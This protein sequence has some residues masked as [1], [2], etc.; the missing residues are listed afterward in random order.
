LIL[1]DDVV[2]NN[3]RVA[4]HYKAIIKALG[5]EISPQKSHQSKSI[6][7]FAKRWIDV[8]QGEFTG[9]PT[10]GIIENFRNAFVVFT[11]LFDYFQLKG[12]QY[13]SEMTFVY[14]V[15]NLITSVN[16]R[17]LSSS[18][19]KRKTLKPGQ[20]KRSF[21]YLSNERLVS[22][23]KPY[24]LFMRYRMG[25]AT[26]DELRLFLCSLTAA[27]PEYQI[28]ATLAGINLEY[29][30]LI[31]HAIIGLAHNLGLKLRMYT[32]T[33]FRDKDSDVSYSTNKTHPLFYCIENRFT[34]LRGIVQ[35]VA[36]R[37]ISLEEVLKELTLFDPDAM[38]KESRGRK[39][40]STI[41]MG[42][43]VKKFVSE[44]KFDPL[45]ME[46]R[47]AAMKVMADFMVQK[48]NMDAMLKQRPQIMDG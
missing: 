2:I 20:F 23:L 31:S 17:F 35:K 41:V 44:T 39:I 21:L 22:I 24:S 27:S 18:R 33:L 46:P 37:T 43:I 4:K 14:S 48:M 38:L 8:N 42:A 30:R 9:L 12:N 25:I 10:R 5:V 47:T 6:Y 7:E 1:G 45:Q 28:P 11:N 34:G 3:D 19:K 36:Q 26:Y 15:A 16:K 29:S 13:F 40:R 32:Q